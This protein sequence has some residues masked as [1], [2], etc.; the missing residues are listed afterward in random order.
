MPAS[1]ADRVRAAK[2][3]KRVAEGEE[4]SDDDSAWY[5]SYEASKRG[6]PIDASAT[7]RITYTEE[8]SAATGDH[9]HPEAY[10]AVARS[11]GLR[12]DTLLRIASEQLVRVCDQYAAI[13]RHLLERTTAIESAHVAM[14]ETVRTH[15]LGRIQAEG[16]A[17]RLTDALAG[18]DGEQSELTQLAG[19][20]VQAMELRNKTVKKPA[21]KAKK[22]KKPL[23]TVE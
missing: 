23:G 5:A 22:A 18:G 9:P 7:E 19:Y 20:I 3:R 17:Q 16:E 11:E 8:R 13:N 1:P 4:L 10:A 14:L 2:L 12:A 15:Y 6:G 21:K